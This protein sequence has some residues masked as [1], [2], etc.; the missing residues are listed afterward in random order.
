MNLKATR[1]KY[2]AVLFSL[3]AFTQVFTLTVS[4]QTENTS[5]GLVFNGDTAAG[6]FDDG[7]NEAA[8]CDEYGDETCVVVDN[9]L[10]GAVY[11]DEYDDETCTVTDD[12]LDYTLYCDEYDDIACEAIDD[13]SAEEE[14]RE[15]EGDNF[16]SLF[17]Y[18]EDVNLMYV[19]T[20][21]AWDNKTINSGRFDYRTLGPNDVISIPLID[22]FKSKFYAHPIANQVTSPFGRRKNEWHYGT[23]VRLKTGDPVKNA[24][25]GI[26]RVIQYDRRGYGNVVVVRHHNGLETLYGHLSKVL[27]KA[28]QDIKAGE[29]V[30]LGGNTGRSTGQHLHFEIRYYGEPFN[31][32]Y[33]VDFDN[34]VLKSGTLVLTRDNFEYLTELRKTV[35]YTVRNGDTLSGI[36]KRH[37]TTVN[38]LCRLNSITAKT[39]LKVG[40]KLVV[41]SGT[42]VE[43]QIVSGSQTQLPTNAQDMQTV[44]I[45][46]FPAVSADGYHTVRGGDT[47]S[48]IAKQY[49]TTTNDLCRLNGITLKT[50]LRVGQQLVVNGS[51]EAK[52]RNAKAAV[53]QQTPAVSADGSYVVREGDN[54]SRIA[55]RYKTTVNDL[56]RL[57]GIT[58]QTVLRVGQRLFLNSGAVVQR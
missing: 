3:F 26:V 43:K 27:V 38:N 48:G 55:Q 11:C 54:L 16:S 28:N 35:Y 17:D 20:S 57:N 7:L 4:A 40:R 50:V 34:H 49:G 33:I 13:D 6:I 51:A 5:P 9:S 56:C 52:P 58:P 45:E 46:E 30:G 12:S 19:D 8:Y 29:T 39:I 47:L 24:L 10:D 1:L 2:S 32:E 21:F 23:D 15:E 53:I 22:S 31:P 25:D 18:M 41:K 36:A 44:D 42:E 14:Y 37:G